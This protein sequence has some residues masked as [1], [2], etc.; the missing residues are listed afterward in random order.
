MAYWHTYPIDVLNLPTRVRNTLVRAGITTLEDL[1]AHSDIELLALRGF[2]PTSLAQVRERLAAWER[3][4]QPEPEKAAPTEPP[5]AILDAEPSAGYEVEQD[6]IALLPGRQVLHATWMPGSPGHLFLWGESMLSSSSKGSTFEAQP[7]PSATHNPQ[8]TI[9]DHP[10]HMPPAT[11]RDVLS[12]LIPPD[13]NA[14]RTLIR[15]PAIGHTP[16][17]SPQLIRDVFAEEPGEP[18]SLGL[19]QVEG[20]AFPPL[21]GLT[22]L[23]DLPR[24][25]DLAPRVTLGADLY[26]WSLAGKLALELLARQ[27]FAPTLQ[28]SVSEPSGQTAQG[29]ASTRRN[30][31]F[32]A[33]WTPILD[34]P[35]D[36]RR[37]EQ[38]VQA[39]PPVC[40]A[41]APPSSEREEG[42]EERDEPPTPRALLK[43]FL[44]TVVDA[45]V[46]AWAPPLLHVVTRQ[47]AP[48]LRAWLTALFSKSDDPV[49][50]AST[51]A[52]KGCRPRSPCGWSS[53]WP[54]RR[55]PSAF[56]SVWNLPRR[57]SATKRHQY[58]LHHRIGHYAFSSRPATI[59]AFWS[60]PAWSGANKAPHCATWTVAS[61]IPRNGSWPAWDWRRASF[62]RSSPACAPP[63]PRYAT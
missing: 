28:Q 62:P 45:A 47:D 32:R 26:F 49:V 37:V 9:R 58:G 5:G 8:S 15:L 3:E 12:G 44:G 61:T 38:L 25:E 14:T 22:F 60:R 19:W 43:D 31:A 17:F 1:L 16:Q 23:N 36:L 40:R 33:L 27:Q 52:L 50:K 34:R 63:V 41:L 55:N 48:I 20:L 7:H 13:V 57:R 51:R 46:R 24:P 35:E 42:N 53:S 54:A 56:A 39:M 4:H 30:G 29:T 10:F 2:G 59:P 11:L 21:A 18:D 6:T